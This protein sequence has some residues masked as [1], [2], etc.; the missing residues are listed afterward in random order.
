MKILF[1]AGE[2]HPEILG[3]IETFGRKMW[4]IFG[5]NIYF[6]AYKPKR[7]KFY[8]IGNIIEI[9]E[10][11]IF[12]KIINKMF[13]NLLRENLLLKEINKLNPEIFILNRPVEIKVLKKIKGKKILVQHI[14]YDIYYKG[15]DYFNK[16][17]KFIRNLIT[18][19]DYFVFLS[20]Y[21]KKRFITEINFPEEKAKVIRP[22]CEIELLKAQKIRTKNLIMICRLDNKQKRID[23]AILGMKKLQDFTLNIYGEGKDRESLE[24]L[25]KENNLKNVFLHEGTNQVKEKLDENSIFIMTSDYEGYPITSIE[26]MRRG[27][28]IVLRNTFDAALDIVQENGIL[29]DKEWDKDKFVEAVR[30]VYDN[31]DYY[32]ENAI[33]MGKRYDFETVKKEWL[34]LIEK[35]RSK[36]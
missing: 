36:N 14:N 15:K 24:N 6:L 5:K 33:K 21:D 20:E 19:L 4:D 29:L 23:L 3:G 25:I 7:K 34:E 26:A 35:T 13:N 17:R 2:S 10:L 16:N 9:K 31:Y 8:K 30:K 32:S 22:T 11:N 27:L 18:E 1:M 12:F 28:P